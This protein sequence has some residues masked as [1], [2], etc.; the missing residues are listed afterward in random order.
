MIHG[1]SDHHLRQ[2]LFDGIQAGGGFRVPPHV[3]ASS[4]MVARESLVRVAQLLKGSQGETLHLFV[5]HDLHL[6]IL[7]E[8]I[9]GSKYRTTE[10]VDFLDGLVLFL[11]GE[12]L[13]VSMHG[14]T[15][16]YG[17]NSGLDESAKGGFQ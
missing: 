12:S 16:T 7:R 3:V 9:F 5:D 6:I 4:D 14:R 1:V 15:A 17:L 13:S 10:W 2:Q 11:K 8:H